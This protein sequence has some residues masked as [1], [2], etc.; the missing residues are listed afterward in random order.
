MTLEL[1]GVNVSLREV[2]RDPA[3]RGTTGWAFAPDTVEF[4]AE[5]DVG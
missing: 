2:A 3:H 1:Q 5:T 4:A